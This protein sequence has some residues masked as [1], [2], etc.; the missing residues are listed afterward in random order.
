MATHLLPH[1]AIPTWSG[2]VYQG[3][4]AL[5]HVLKQ[6]NLK[7]VLEINSMVLQLD[8]IEDFAI[9]QVNGANRTTISMHQ[10]K[11][12]KSNLYSTYSAD[13]KQLEDK[14]TKMGI[15]N[16]K[17]YFHL[18]TK[19][20]ETKAQIEALHPL[21]NI[22]TYEH[23]AEACP[24]VDIGGKISEQIVLALQRFQMSGHDNATNVQLM[25][26]VLEKKV[27]NK[28]VEIHSMNHKGIDIR[29]AAY[30][31][32]IPLN[33]FLA[34]IQSD[35][36]LLVQNEP[37]FETKVRSNL[38]RYYQEFWYDM[39]DGKKTKETQQKMDCFLMYFNSLDLT[40]LKA[41]MQKI[42]PHK[43]IAFANLEEFTDGSLNEVEVKDA[44]FTILSEIKASNNNHGCGWITD[45]FMHFHPTSITESNS[46]AGKIRISKKI[47]ETALNTTVEVP[48]DSD[49]LVTNE[50][51]VDSIQLASNKIHEMTE[52]ENEKIIN[53]KNIALVSLETAKNKLN[54]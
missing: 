18:A 33:E 4:V 35:L 43:K 13:F 29:Q 28:V 53:W 24:L 9:L 41:F 15:A 8:S 5:Y 46:E 52:L 39:E 48:F 11:A 12:V 20:Q 44:F 23:G 2:F 38:N 37:Y 14:W 30:E 32:T 19:N 45:D 21:I 10:V 6:L 36:S 42:R 54:G 3:Q 25:S 17:A 47:L 27:T 40:G 49:F 7:T 34:L 51:N 1:T 26:E 31:N 22:Y 16:A 50:C